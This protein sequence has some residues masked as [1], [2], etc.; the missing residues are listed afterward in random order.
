MSNDSQVVR[1]C[2]ICEVLK[3]TGHSR[4]GLYAAVAAGQ[5]PAPVKIGRRCSA[6]PES[7]VM[8]WQQAR[9]D[10]RDETAHVKVAASS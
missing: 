2:R 10:A 5:F 1:F 7:E 6:W 8:A 3:R 4:S 9:I